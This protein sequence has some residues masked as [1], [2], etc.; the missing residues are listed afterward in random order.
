M[1]ALLFDRVTLF[2]DRL[3]PADGDPCRVADLGLGARESLRLHA[4]ELVLVGVPGRNVDLA[5]D[6]L[7]VGADAIVVAPPDG[8]GASVR[9]VAQHIDGRLTISGAAR[10]SGADA[11]PPGRI[12][13]WYATATAEPTV[14]APGF[15]VDLIQMPDT[16]ELW[17]RWQLSQGH[18]VSNV[19]AVGADLL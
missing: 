6:R 12:T 17:S 13:V 1:P 11:E 19:S 15:S 4:A 3:R 7:V 5:A 9:I 18:A 14:D 8:P 16:Q 2:E 10:A